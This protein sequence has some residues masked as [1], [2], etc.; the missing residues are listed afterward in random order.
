MM[1]WMSSLRKGKLGLVV[2]K[3]VWTTRWV[4]GNY[5]NYIFESFKGW[6]I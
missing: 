3:E 5:K 1:K 4:N 6:C 2:I